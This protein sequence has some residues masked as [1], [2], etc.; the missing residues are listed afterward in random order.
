MGT[1]LANVRH[2]KTV[3]RRRRK[4]RHTDCNAY[5]IFVAS[6][7]NEYYYD[8]LLKIIIFSS[9]ASIPSYIVT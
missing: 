4:V 7:E 2:S 8:T 1:E 6:F 9:D 5:I 3:G